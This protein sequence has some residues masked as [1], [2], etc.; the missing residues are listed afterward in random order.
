MDQEHASNLDIV[1]SGQ[2]RIDGAPDGAQ[3]FGESPMRTSSM[4]IG[5]TALSLV[6]AIALITGCQSTHEEG[7]KSNLRSQWA[8]VSGNTTTTTAAAQ[9][10]LEGEG[11]KEV[12]SSSTAVDG[13]ATGKK[14]DGTEVKVAIA[15]KT[16]TTSEVTVTVGTMGDPTLGANIARKIKEKVEM[17]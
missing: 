16:D 3:T 4:R 9:A 10:V 7:I 1:C 8:M 2:A 13:T 12:K 14:A 6:A 17:P 11:L 15:K 5:L